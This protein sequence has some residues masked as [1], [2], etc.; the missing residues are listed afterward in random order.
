MIDGMLDMLTIGVA[1]IRLDGEVMYANK[2]AQGMLSNCGI[3]LESSNFPIAKQRIQDSTLKK[4]RLDKQETIVIRNRNCELQIQI[5]PFNNTKLEQNSNVE[6]RRGAMLILHES[7]RVALPSLQQLKSLYGLT[8]AEARI[9]IKLCEGNSPSE[10]AKNMGVSITT[11]RTQLRALMEKTN[12][13]RQTEL[14]TKLLSS[15]SASISL[16]KIRM[17]EGILIDKSTN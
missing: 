1:C 12:S 2:A 10:C 14:L 16:E 15:P 13:H 9:A 7:G 4:L 11:I 5:A 3:L 8:H 17:P 6:R